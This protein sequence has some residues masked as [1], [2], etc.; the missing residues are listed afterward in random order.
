MI[1]FK[2]VAYSYFNDPENTFLEIFTTDAEERL[3]RFLEEKDS[4][5]WTIKR[6]L[7]VPQGTAIIELNFLQDYFRTILAY[8]SGGE[9]A[10]GSVSFFYFCMEGETVEPLIDVH[11][12]SGDLICEVPW[13]LQYCDELGISK[14]EKFFLVPYSFDN[15]WY[16]PYHVDNHY[17]C[18]GN[19]PDLNLSLKQFVESLRGLS[20][21][22]IRM[23][24]DKLEVRYTYG[25]LPKTQKT[26]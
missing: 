23:E 16:P 12:L 2:L 22:E 9:M 1:S 19:V 10:K 7:H 8:G 17:Y 13:S 24:L 3:T 20:N 25:M 14:I 21:D 15:D 5:K 18:L 26:K 4:E 6:I 11:R